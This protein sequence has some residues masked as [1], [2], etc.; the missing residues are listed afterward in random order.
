[1]GEGSDEPVSLGE[2]GNFLAFAEAD[3]VGGAATGGAEVVDEE[4]RYGGRF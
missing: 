4:Q 3:G 1:M 2:E